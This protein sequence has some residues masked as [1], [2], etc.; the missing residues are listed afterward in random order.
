MQEVTAE[1]EPRVGVCYD[2]VRGYNFVD[3]VAAL[4]VFLDVGH[5]YDGGD[6]V[7]ISRLKTGGYIEEVS[8]EGHYRFTEKG[9]QAIIGLI[10]LGLSDR[11]ISFEDE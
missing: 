4:S 2:F 3:D 8:G 10:A 7:R 5:S 1:A 9:R 11:E 6:K